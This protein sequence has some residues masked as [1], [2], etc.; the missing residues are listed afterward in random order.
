MTMTLTHWRQTDVVRQTP[1]KD[2]VSAAAR[3][4]VEHKSADVQPWIG[5]LLAGA[6]QD[7]APQPLGDSAGFPILAS[8]LLCLTLGTV[9]QEQQPSLLL[10]NIVLLGCC[11]LRILTGVATSGALVQH[12]HSIRASLQ[13]TSAPLKL[14]TIRQ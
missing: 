9:P 5:T 7:V 3:I 13:V 6:R 12:T 14:T 11:H 4:L 10:C 2:W 1:T 8:T